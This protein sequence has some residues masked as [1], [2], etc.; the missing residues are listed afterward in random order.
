MTSRAAPCAAFA[1]PRSCRAGAPAEPPGTR[2][3]NREVGLATGCA[4]ELGGIGQEMQADCPG[5]RLWGRPPTNRGHAKIMDTHD[6]ARL[7]KIQLHSSIRLCNVKV[8]HRKA[9][10]GNEPWR[11]CRGTVRSSTPRW[12]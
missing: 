4:A 7:A 11:I 10:Q 2:A 6:D 12:F 9:G 3:S 1:G 5:S 8:R